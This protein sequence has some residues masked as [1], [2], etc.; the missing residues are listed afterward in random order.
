MSAL[1]RALTRRLP[2]RPERAGRRTRDER[3]VASLE[4]LGMVPLALV[5]AILAVQVAAFMWAVTSTN[6]AVRQGARAQSLGQDGCAAARAVLSD[7]LQVVDCVNGG[8]MGSGSTVRLEVDI[9]VAG[10]VEDLVP[11]VRVTREAFLP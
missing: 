1:R 2:L 8:R 6:D 3:G 4:L 9:P 7:S 11:D 10:A 5:F